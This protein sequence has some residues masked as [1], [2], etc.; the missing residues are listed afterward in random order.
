M[1]ILKKELSREVQDEIYGLQSEHRQ[2][3]EELINQHV[4]THLR[5]IQNVS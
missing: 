5:L 2:K 3:I 4:N 1:K